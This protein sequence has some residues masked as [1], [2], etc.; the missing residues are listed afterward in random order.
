MSLVKPSS[1]SSLNEG[2][3]VIIAHAK[4]NDKGHTSIVYCLEVDGDFQN[5]EGCVVG[6]PLR[7]LNRCGRRMVQRRVEKR[8]YLY[9]WINKFLSERL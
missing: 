2:N 8:T 6:S 9:S 1:S 5:G 7:L 3:A 4:A